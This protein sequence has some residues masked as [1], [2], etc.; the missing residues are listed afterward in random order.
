MM[1]RNAASGQHLYPAIIAPDTHD[2]EEQIAA[3]EKL[4]VKQW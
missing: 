2:S 1:V 3:S 4:L